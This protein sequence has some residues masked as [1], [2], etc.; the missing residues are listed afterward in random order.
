MDEESTTNKKNKSNVLVWKGKNG[1]KDLVIDR[2]DHRV[3]QDVIERLMRNYNF[4]DKDDQW[5]LVRTHVMVK[6]QDGDERRVT[7][8]TLEPFNHFGIGFRSWSFPSSIGLLQSLEKLN[9]S[10]SGLSTLPAELGN[11]TNLVW[12]NLWHTNISTLPTSIGRLKNL[13]KLDLSCAKMLSHLPEEIGDLSSLKQMALN[14]TSVSSLPTSIGRLKS[15]QE[16]FLEF[17]EKLSHLPEEIG[18]LSNLK[19]LELRC[20]GVVSLP[21]SIGRLQSLQELNLKYTEKLSHLPVEVGNLSNLKILDLSSSGITKLP[22][23][24]GNLKNLQTLNVNS[25]ENLSVLPEEIGRLLNLKSLCA[26]N[27]KIRSLPTSVAKLTKLTHIDLSDS[28]LAALPKSFRYL[29]GPL[30]MYVDHTPLSKNTA[31]LLSI[32]PCSLGAVGFETEDNGPEILR[33]ALAC[34]RARFRLGATHGR[35][36]VLGSMP[37]LWPYVLTNTTRIFQA[38]PNTYRHASFYDYAN[39]VPEPRETCYYAINDLDAVYRILS[40]ESESFVGILKMRQAKSNGTVVSNTLRP[41]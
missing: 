40:M 2:G 18:N 3:V 14:G 8:L 26:H 10:N 28:N 37:T 41:N 24:I 13:E 36:R 15:L 20:S 19:V 38:Y 16:L 33:H 6:V 27:T 5:S 11:L 12:L 39:W 29:E 30:N 23:F 31:R 25:I 17:A 21:T 4:N 34:N 35:K 9:I 1:T 7:E 32:F 22:V